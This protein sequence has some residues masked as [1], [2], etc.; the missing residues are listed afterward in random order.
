MSKNSLYLMYEKI[1]NNYIGKAISELTS[2]LGIKEDIDP[3][4]L[5]MLFRGKEI[6]K[7]VEKIA[8]YLGLPVS[9]DLSYAPQKQKHGLIN[10]HGFGLKAAEV[11]IPGN[12]P[13]YGTARLRGFTIKVKIRDSCFRNEWSFLTIMAHE[14]SHIVLHS[15]SHAE[16]NNEFYTDLTAMV[17]GFSEV[18]R[19]GRNVVERVEGTLFTKEYNKS[20]GYLSNNQFEYAYRRNRE[21]LARK[22]NF[23]YMIRQKLSSQKKLQNK[24][25]K[26]LDKFEGWV[27]Y[28]DKKSHIKMGKSDAVKIVTFHQPGYL[29]EFNSLMNN[30]NKRMKDINNF[31]IQL[32]HYSQRNINVLN[33]MIQEVDESLLKLSNG[34]KKMG[35]DLKI[36]RKYT[37]IFSGIRMG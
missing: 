2:Q 9:I 18:M 25:Q 3:D 13:F 20:Y 8:D 6:K 35:E 27:E 11:Y 21:I 34:Y 29:D 10:G 26:R 30:S 32:R 16:K 23:K 28:L 7:C 4:P 15:I 14:I 5:L 36:M 33:G 37:G 22:V 17:L 12:L 24:L 31:C 19:Y 1:D